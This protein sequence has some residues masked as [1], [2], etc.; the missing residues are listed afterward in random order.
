MILVEM[1]SL[2]MVARLG[3]LQWSLGTW[4]FLCRRCGCSF[5]SMLGLAS[6][7]QVHGP[8]SGERLHCE[9]LRRTYSSTTRQDP[10]VLAQRVPCLLGATNKQTSAEGSC[11]ATRFMRNRCPCG[12]NLQFTLNAAFSA[13]FGAELNLHG[14]NADLPQ[15]LLEAWNLLTMLPYCT[16]HRGCIRCGRE[17]RP[18]SMRLDGFLV[19]HDEEACWAFG[20]LIW[21]T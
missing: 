20:F 2:H 11:I 18:S 7:V 5:L 12:V 4:L 17:R 6:F 13:A 10:E 8:C 3:D 15:I 14:G 19:P 16:S 21:L 1:N 9:R